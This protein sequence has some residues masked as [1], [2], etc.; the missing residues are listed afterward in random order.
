M[1]TAHAI[2]S[3][4]SVSYCVFIVLKASGS[5]FISVFVLATNGHTKLFHAPTKVKI[6]SAR[7][8]DFDMLP[9]R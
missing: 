2:V 3:P 5:V 1:I 4:T 6:E 7:T 9:S 8:D